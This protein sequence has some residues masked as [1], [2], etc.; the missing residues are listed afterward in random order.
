MFFSKTRLILS[1]IIGILLS[2]LIASLVNSVLMVTADND[3]NIHTLKGDVANLLAAEAMDDINRLNMLNMLETQALEEAAA[4]T[5]DLN[6]YLQLLE[7]QALEEAAA[8]TDDLKGLILD[9][10]ARA[11]S[12]FRD[13]I[14]KIGTRNSRRYVTLHNRNIALAKVK[15]NLKGYQEDR[16]T[17]NLSQKSYRSEKWVNNITW[18]IAICGLIITIPFSLLMLY[19]VTVVWFFILNRISEL[20]NAIQGKR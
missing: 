5:D 11:I 4:T 6:R 15:I 7:A 20:S 19:V 1:I 2:V 9:I 10:E 3:E 17:I 12:N 13:E 16:D 18:V 8:T 14:D